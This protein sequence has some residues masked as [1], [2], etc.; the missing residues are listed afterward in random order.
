MMFLVY[1][2]ELATVLRKHGISVHLFAGDVKL[3]LKKPPVFQ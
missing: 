1:I 2:D 3:Y